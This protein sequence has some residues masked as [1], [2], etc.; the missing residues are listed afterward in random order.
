MLFSAVSLILP[1]YLDSGKAMKRISVIFLLLSVAFSQTPFRRGVNL[2]NWF[3]NNDAH[4]IQFNKFGAEDLREIK[5]LGCDVIRLPI[6]V[7]AMTSGPPDYTI[8]PL[9]FYFLDQV[10]DLTESL[11]LY[12]ILD[13]HSFNP[14]V[15]TKPEVEEILNAVWRQMARHFKNRSKRV[16]YE[17]LNEPHGIADSV[18]NRIQQSVIT[19]IRSVDT[20]HTIV[21]G[22]A[23]WNS[24]HNLQY[25]PSYADSNLIYT[26]HFYEPF[27]F[28][29]QGAGWTNPPMLSLAG[30]PFPYIDSRMPS[31]PPDLQGTW[32]E[33]AL[34]NY[35]NTGTVGYVR[36]QLDMAIRFAEQRRVPVFCGEMGVYMPNSASSDRNIWYR[37]VRSYLEDHG[38]AWTM[39]DYK[40]G[41]GLFEKGSDELF[42]YDLNIPLLNALGFQVP[43]QQE[44]VLRPDSAGFILYDDYTGKGIMQT[45]YSPVSALDYYNQDNPHAGKFCLY[46]SDAQQYG[47]LGFDFV[48]NKDLSYLKANDFVLSFWLRAEGQRTSFDVRFVDTKTNDANDHPWRMK[49][50]ISSDEINW[51]GLWQ[52]IRIPLKDFK[53]GG[54]WDNGWFNPQGKF[55]WRHIDRFE[56]VAEQNSMSGSRLWFDDIRVTNSQVIGIKQ[57]KIPVINQFALF[58]IYPNPFN[59]RIRIKFDILHPMPVRLEIFNIRGQRVRTLLKKIL[60]KGSYSFIWNG[61]DDQGKLLPGGLYLVRLKTSGQSHTQKIVYVR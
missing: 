27:V 47:S 5:S 23:G 41:F 7:H 58:R 4:R 25:M 13:N 30:V 26:F 15:N 57:N 21:V 11:N 45:N 10:I 35:P 32:I 8:D 16:L 36:G 46:W 48:P 38:I 33:S 54:S 60:A 56:I 37:I 20:V 31:C 50:T 3:Q 53:E 1:Q 18:W 34:D 61:C 29:H 44:F 28:T 12:L 40:G 59:S 51:N 42:Q 49:A 9:L 24:Y 2:T 55:D 19:T 39:W 52:E 43:E 17:V 22:P 14:A 6:N